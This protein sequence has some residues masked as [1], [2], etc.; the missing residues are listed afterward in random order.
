MIF[1]MLRHTILLFAVCATAAAACA[2]EP[3]PLWTAYQAAP[4]T[5]ANLPNCSYAGYRNGDVPLPNPT[6]NII[7]VKSAPYLAK[8]DGAT[9]DTTAIRNAISAVG[10]SGGVVFSRMATT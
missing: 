1:K 10:G 7:N 4:D 2:E 3:S 8:G 9:D 5:H 6:T